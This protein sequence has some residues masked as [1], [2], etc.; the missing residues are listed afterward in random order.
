[1]NSVCSV[2]VVCDLFAVCSVFG[3]CVMWDIFVFVVYVC[4]CFA[5]W[6]VSDMR[7]V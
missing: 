2:C 5:F 4:T 6:V 7:C 3:L 1:M